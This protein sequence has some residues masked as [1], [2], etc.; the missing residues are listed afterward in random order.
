MGHLPAPPR[1]SGCSLTSVYKALPGWS[2]SPQPHLN[3]VTWFCRF[4]A[5]FPT[6]L[7]CQGHSPPLL[8]FSDTFSQCSFSY[9]HHPTLSPPYFLY[10]PSSPSPFPLSSPIVFAQSLLEQLSS[11]KR[12]TP[13]LDCHLLTNTVPLSCNPMKQLVCAK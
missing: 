13:S 4:H 12:P 1:L 8:F 11:R 7:E 10:P 2:R 3:G 9:S 6:R 5:S